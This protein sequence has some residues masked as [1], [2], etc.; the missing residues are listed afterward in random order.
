MSAGHPSHR[1]R[2]IGDSLGQG[3][4][5]PNC[6]PPRNGRPRYRRPRTAR[7][8]CRIPS[9]AELFALAAV[10]A[11]LAMAVALYIRNS[12]FGL[13]LAGVRDNEA[14]GVGLGVAVYRHRFAAFL[15]SS[16]LTGMAGTASSPVTN[17]AAARRGSTRENRPANESITRSL[18]CRHRAGSTLWLS[19]T[20]RSD[21]VST[22]YRRSCGGRPH[23]RGIRG[24]LTSGGCRTTP[25]RRLARVPGL[26]RDGGTRRSPVLCRVRRRLRWLG[27]RTRWPVRVRPRTGRTPSI[28]R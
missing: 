10:V 15:A 4:F 11:G 19:A 1:A 17:P 13:R 28:G 25:V 6:G 3:G 24:H 26:G 9:G 22:T 21:V 18:I 16:V 20:A 8:R 7:S 14:A 23:S 2:P 5:S 12:A 27:N